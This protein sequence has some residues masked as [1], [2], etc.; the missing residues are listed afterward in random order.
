MATESKFQDSVIEWHHKAIQRYVPSFSRDGTIL[1]VL[2]I[3]V[4]INERIDLQTRVWPQLRIITETR[5]D[6]GPNY[7][8]WFWHIDDIIEDLGKEAEAIYSPK[9]ANDFE[10]AKHLILGMVL[11]KYTKLQAP[12]DESFPIPSI[13]LPATLPRWNLPEMRHILN[14][15]TIC[16]TVVET[17]S[18]NRLGPQLCLVPYWIEV[19]DIVCQSIGCTTPVV[20]RHVEDGNFRFI[21]DCYV[22]EKPG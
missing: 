22:Y 18:T 8:L 4:A 15:N 20:L 19:G 10:C 12:S 5:T 6:C 3:Q 16:R 13:T 2:G 1:N 21:G 17:S 11:L 7:S 14:N 9:W